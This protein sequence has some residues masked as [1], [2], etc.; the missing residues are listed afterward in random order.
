MILPDVN[1][2][3]YAEDVDSRFNQRAR[4]WWDAQL[5]GTEPVCLSWD[6]IAA[7]LRLSTHHGAFPEPLSQTTAISR[8]QTW[9]AQPY[10]RVIHPTENHWALFQLMLKDSQAVGKLVPDA[11]LAALAIEH[12]CV[13]FSADADFA[14]FPKLK[15]KNPLK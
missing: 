11:H 4:V 13:L 1:L 8:V 6:T 15:W 10:V 2:L 5:S 3:L 7:F 9:L 14:R 12:G